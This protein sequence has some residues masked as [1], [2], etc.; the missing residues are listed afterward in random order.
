MGGGGSRVSLGSRFPSGCRVSSFPCEGGV[1][2]PLFGRGGLRR[3]VHYGG[4]RE[5]EFCRGAPPSSHFL[6][7]SPGYFGFPGGGDVGFH[8]RLAPEGVCDGVLPSRAPPFF[9]DVFRPEGRDGQ[10]ADYRPLSLEQAPDK[11]TVQDG[12]FG[13]GGQVPFPRSLGGQVGPQRCLPSPSP[14]SAGG[15]VFWVRPGEEDFCLPR[16]PFWSLPGSLALHE[17]DEAGEKGFAS[18]GGEDLF[19]FGRFPH[20]GRFISGGGGAHQAFCGPSSAP[21]LPHQLAEVRGGS[22]EAPGV[23]GSHSRP[24]EPDL[25]SSRGEGGEGSFLTQGFGRTF[26]SEVGPGVA[27]GL[28]QFCRLLPSSGSPLDQAPSVVDELALLS[29]GPSGEGSDRPCLP[30]GPPSLGGQVLPGGLGPRSSGLPLSGLDDGCLSLGLGRSCSPP[31]GSWGVGG[32]P[33][34]HVDQLVGVESHPLGS[35][36]LFA[37]S[38]G[39]LRL[40]E[41][42]QHDRSG[43]HQ[44]AGFPGLSGAVVPV[45][46]DSGSCLAV[47]HSSGSSSPER[48]LECPGGQGVSALSNLHG[49][50]SGRRL[51]SAPLR[52]SW[53]PSGRFDGDIGE[54]Q[55]VQVR[56]SVPGQQGLRER[57]LRF[58]LGSVGFD[59]PLPALPVASGGGAQVELLPGRGVPHRPPL[60]LGPVVRPP[61]GQV[62]TQTSPQRRPLVVPVDLSGPGHHVGGGLLQSSRLGLMRSSLLNDGFS[63]AAVSYFL[64]CHKSSTRSQYQ[65][66]WSRFLSFLASEQVNPGDVRL[67][68]VHNFLAEEA[69][70]NKR[71]Y[72][73]VA[74]YKC[75]LAL[76]LKVGWNLDLDNPLTRKFMM[77]VWNGN[78]PTPRPMPKWDLTSLLLFVRS[79]LFEDLRVVSF[80]LL[81]QKVLVLL[82]IAS[83]RR[84]SEI[85]NLSRVTSVVDGRTFVEW[86]PDFRAKWCSAH[87]GFIP[88]S[89]SA[90]PLAS[91]SERHLRNCPVRALTIFLERRRLVVNRLNN[92][93]LWTLSQSGLASAFRS[94]VRA[95]LAHV[96]DSRVLSIYPHQTKKFAIS[97]CWKY[98]SLDYVKERLPARA[99]NSSV[100]VL[101][102]SYLGSVPNIGIH[103][104]VPLGTISPSS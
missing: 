83:G 23:S 40:S 79:D 86:L 77:G 18:A 74:T 22:P 2:S 81:T 47:W 102:G 70:V 69:L 62:S 28:P 13:E 68:H 90:L 72:R 91:E 97:Y 11:D 10:A 58:R 42:G 31:S 66:T 9:K 30:G 76:P 38:R 71:A 33:G 12:G 54:R 61:S 50:V 52:P 25:L 75:A 67:C 35:P 19:V 94:V 55:T 7:G 51:L 103:C 78:P 36:S 93:C 14:G 5:P 59:L 29:S 98:F 99:G 53:N 21:G 89:P 3:L 92:D 48:V 60:A 85:A 57:C 95:S 80:S 8:P 39:S 24:G 32:W 65:S 34:G 64:S 84:L 104:V 63:E 16:A 26:G 20:S 17:G 87:S 1:D 6:S 49:V 45:S 88:Q 82:L 101:K 43:L 27:G 4:W 41:V 46:G 15:E 37:S 96:G 100:K 44:E 56:I 73:T